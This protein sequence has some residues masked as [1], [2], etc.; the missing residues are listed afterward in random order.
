[1]N[2]N[3]KKGHKRKVIALLIFSLVF[4]LCIGFAQPIRAEGASFY[5]LP[6]FRIY[7]AGEKFSLDIMIDVEGACIN[8][9]QAIIYFPSQ[10][11]QVVE[12]STTDSMFS[13]WIQGPDWS[14]EKGEIS[15]V[16][17]LPS[18]GFMG[19]GGKV[20][21]ITFKALSSGQAEVSFGQERILANEPEGTDV[22]S[23]SKEGR[24]P[25]TS[26]KFEITV[27]NEG[28]STNPR[29]V[30]YL[31]IVS[32]VSDINYY[33]VEIGEEIFT[34]KKE[35]ITSWQLPTLTPGEHL[36]LVKAVTET[37]EVIESAIEVLVES[38]PV[39]QITFCPKT[40]RSGEEI[41]YID[42]SALPDS[43]VL[44]FL[45]ESGDLIT[46]WEVNSDSEGNWS[47]RNESVLR[48]G[49][50]RIL[51]KTRDAR[52]A[53]SLASEGCLV[54]VILGGITMGPFVLAYKSLAVAS[55]IILIFLLT[56]LLYSFLRIK[57]LQESIERETLD[58]KEKF[59]KEY[60][61]L[62][63]DIEKEI[64]LL[65]EAKKEKGLT[66]EEER[67]EKELLKNLEDVERVL[68]EELRDI[69]KIK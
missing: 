4:L 65:R 48:P 68:R 37:G 62:K 42:G 33:E 22:F 54:N 19:K 53:I 41:L 40:F 24:Y 56:W 59:Y 44:I 15:F 36:I 47:L 34:V 3:S 18:P 35:E 9:A 58:L 67:L 64:E 69:E 5:V 1:M 60:N 51:A 57:K 8:A 2:K 28:D 23:F 61:E 16:G 52:G 38:I 39:P 30:L 25:I 50:Y 14:N 27:D 13:F 31:S 49:V 26:S 20:M 10:K 6:S 29:P 66:D 63:R 55:I 45:E 11:L 32:D 17:G 7:R 21:T 43:S 12:I 46:K